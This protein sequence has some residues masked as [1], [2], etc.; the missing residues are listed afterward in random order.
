VAGSLLINK[1][2]NNDRWWLLT[3]GSPPPNSCGLFRRYSA[4]LRCL[5]RRILHEHMESKRLPFP[6]TIT[7][8][9]NL[10]SQIFIEVLTHPSGASNGTTY[11]QFNQT[12]IL[13][14]N[15]LINPDLLA[16]QGLPWV[17]A[18]FAVYV[19]TTNLSTTATFSHLLL[20]NYNDMKTAWAFATFANLKK[21]LHPRSWNLR[22]WRSSTTNPED[23][24]ETDP[25]Y[26]LMLV[27]KDAPDW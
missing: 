24:P 12:A 4:K 1:E 13:D 19:L 6:F 7:I 10:T 8:H 14:S 11:V 25:H 2:A 15:N 21:T 23:D 9:V 27:Y 18:T 16:E 3:N 17:S 22:F 5:C 26:R 20:W